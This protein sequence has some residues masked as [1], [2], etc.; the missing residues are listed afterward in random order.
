MLKIKN[1]K[2]L[3]CGNEAIAQGAF[4]AG[5]RLAT[6]YPGTPASEIMNYLLRLKGDDFYAEW[7]N[8]EK[9][10][11]EICF[12]AST[13]NQRSLCSMKANGFN[14]CIDSL[15]SLTKKG[16]TGGLV[17]A[18]VDDPEERYSDVIQDTRK[19]MKIIGFPVLEPKTVKECLGMTKEAF[20]ISEKKGVPVFIRTT[21]KIGHLYSPVK[22]GKR[23]Q[24]RR[25]KFDNTPYKFN[26]YSKE[27]QKIIP[28]F[29]PGC[30]HD[31]FYQKFSLPEEYV[32]NGD[33]G[34]YEMAGFGNNG[35]DDKPIR[36]I[37][38]I[39]SIDE[40]LRNGLWRRQGG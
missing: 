40:P 12:G 17:V 36:E 4:E 18:V 33:I 14:W 21:N 13:V 29:C 32:V 16:V 20:E 6:S 3:L 5:A 26:P 10:A 27:K 23:A 37:I 15:M 34:C 19:F 11:L 28:Y 1:K 31:A 24:L 9:V 7:S 30:P 8:N 38:Q 35:R 25:L 2:V 22:I 39:D